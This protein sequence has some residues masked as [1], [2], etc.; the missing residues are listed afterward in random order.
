V[1]HDWME[2]RPAAEVELLNSTLLRKF[3]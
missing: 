1:R 2:K 3:Q